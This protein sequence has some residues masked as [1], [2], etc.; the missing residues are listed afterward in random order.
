M[1]A[2]AEVGL[3]VMFYDREIR[4]AVGCASPVL[5]DPDLQHR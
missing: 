5:C 2:A 1:L 3:A 4:D